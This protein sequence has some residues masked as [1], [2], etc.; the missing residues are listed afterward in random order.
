MPSSG[1]SYVAMLAIGSCVESASIH[2]FIKANATIIQ[3]TIPAIHLSITSGWGEQ[4]TW[5]GSK[6]GAWG[7][8]VQPGWVGMRMD[9]SSAS[10]GLGGLGGWIPWPF[11]Y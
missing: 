3:I 5:Q 4:K 6:A 7:V 11:V 8:N 10:A 1:S 2:P 9:S